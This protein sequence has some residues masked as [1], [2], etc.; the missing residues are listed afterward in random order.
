[1]MVELTKLVNKLESGSRPKGGVKNNSIGIPS[2]GAEHLN[3]NGGFNFN[4]V[5]F[6]PEEFFG[7]QKNGVIEFEDILV[8]KDGA[9]TG[10]VSF[11]DEGF[12]YKKASINEHV[13]KLSINKDLALPKF[14]F[15]HLFSNVGK[16]QILEDFRGATVG[17]IS[18][19]FID[20]V[21]IP[22]PSLEDQKRVVRELDAADALRKKRKQAIALLDDYLKAVFLE[23]FGDPVT[24][25][26]KLEMRKFG[27]VIEDIRYGSSEKSADRQNDGTVAILRIPNILNGYVNFNDLKFQ[28]LSQKETWK[29]SLFTG[30]IL[31]VRTN[32]NPDYIGRCAV[33]ENSMPCVFA[34]YLI[35]VRLGRNSGFAPMFIRYCFSMDCYRGKIRKESRT[36]AGNYNINT[37]GIKNFDLISPSLSMQERF[38]AM[39]RNT[40][41]LKGL[42]NNQSNEL[43]IN[44]NALMQGAFNA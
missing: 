24:N 28:S 44:F 42:M 25:P 33:Y 40:E 10:K 35:R 14:I 9:T 20:M 4:K 26:K 27:E 38:V 7:R 36:T 21:K 37:Q 17:G 1:M 5:K 23:M 29:L 13:F 43:D 39:L 16:Q 19:G 22:L 12:P 31:F 34:S 6:V 3:A 2:L 18:R 8:V 32:G 41:Q 30:D 11:V 15:W